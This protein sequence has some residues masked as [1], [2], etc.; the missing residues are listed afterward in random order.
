MKIKIKSI[1]ETEVDVIFPQIKKTE[2]NYYYYQSEKKLFMISSS[3]NQLTITVSP[4]F[5]LEGLEKGVDMTIEEWNEVAAKAKENLNL[6]P[7]TL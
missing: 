2:H 1:T 5:W 7:S 3:R 4:S 6:L